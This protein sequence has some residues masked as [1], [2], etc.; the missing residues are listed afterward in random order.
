M[1]LAETT[2][3]TNI[4]SAIY[5]MY[6]E[7]ILGYLKSILNIAGLLVHLALGTL[8]QATHIKCKAFHK[9]ELL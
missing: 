9:T 1:T 3:V 7:S 4:T 6:L 8:A 5:Y 2:K